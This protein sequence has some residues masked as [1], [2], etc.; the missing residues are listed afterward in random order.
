M[1]NIIYLKLEG[2]QQGLIS[3]GCCTSDSI[4]NKY[5]SGKEDY[6]FITEFDCAVT[7]DQN[8]SHHPIDFV[9]L[10]D[11]S[12]PLILVAIANNE[13][14]TLTFDFFRISQHGGPEKYYTIK[15]NEASIVNY[16][17]RSPNNIL[18][19][20]I[21]LEEYIS[22]KYRDI[23]TSHI[24]AGTSGYSITDDNNY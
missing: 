23:T 12:S 16:A 17:T 7:R 5:Q 13:R 9:K 19:N 6:I 8:L 24:M 4:G 15:L 21:Q 11:K 2:K 14:L 1:A 3:R 20:D 22:V 18:R 10:I